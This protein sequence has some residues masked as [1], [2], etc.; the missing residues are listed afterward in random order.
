MPFAAK[1]SRRQT[2]AAMAAASTLSVPTLSLAAENRM[3]GALMILST[4]YTAS[5]ETD[6]K[7]LAKEVDFCGRC[8]VQGLVWP[9]NSSEQ[10]YLSKEERLRGF[11]TPAAAN[12]GRGMALVLGVQAEDTAG[13]LEYARAAEAVARWIAAELPVAG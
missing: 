5:G 11:E 10:L 1:F 6:Y 4:P 9:Q 12:R 7:D 13:M 8:G 2:L 3:R